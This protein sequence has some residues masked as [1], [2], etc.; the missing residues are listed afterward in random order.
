[1]NLGACL[2]RAVREDRALTELIQIGLLAKIC[3]I[4][5]ICLA[6]H[7]MPFCAPCYYGNFLHPATDPITQ[8]SAFKTWDG[9]HYAFLAE[10]WY[11]PGRASNAFYPL[12]PLAVRLLR[13]IFLNNTLITGLILSN[14]FAIGALIL[15]Y[16]LARE[17]FDERTAFYAGLFFLAF[18]SSYYTGLMYT[19]SLFLLLAL[20]LFHSLYRNMFF[21]AL[22]ASALLPLARPQGVLLLIPLSVYLLIKVPVTKGLRPDRRYL[23]PLALLGGFV[24]YLGIMEAATGDAFAGFAAQNAFASGN[25]IGNLVHPWRWFQTNFMTLPSGFPGLTMFLVDRAFLVGFLLILLLIYR[26]LDK[27]LFTYAAVLGLVVVFSG[28]FIAY[29]RFLLVVFPIFIVLGHR[30]K[31]RHYLV[32]IPSVALQLLFLIAH[33]LNYWVA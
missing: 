28:I 17:I 27:V 3:V 20:L 8:T 13:F 12:Y 33:S 31:E 7:L 32:T 11:G 22:A 1:M 18:P 30:L 24:A 29:T 2:P 14:I 21:P 26:H 4:A 5:T 23:L 9:Q 16:L 19:E 25:A 15:L 6:Y 10:Q